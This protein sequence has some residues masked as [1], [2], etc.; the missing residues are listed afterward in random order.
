[1]ISGVRQDVE[2]KKY[3]LACNRI[4]EYMHEAE[5]KRDK[6]NDGGSGGGSHG[7]VIKE[8]IIHPNDYFLKSWVLKNP[9][10]AI[11]ANAANVANAAT[12]SQSALKADED[13][14]MD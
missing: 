4:F 14:I 3:H 6:D 2:A 11:A 9:G 1:V 7:V 12:A 8:T 5:L 13:V 10:A